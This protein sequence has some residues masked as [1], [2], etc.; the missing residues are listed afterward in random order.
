MAAVGTTGEVSDRRSISRRWRPGDVVDVDA[1]DG[2]EF[3]AVVL[4]PA[5]SGDVEEMSIKFADGVIDDWPIEEFCKPAKISEASSSEQL[6]RYDSEHVVVVGGGVIGLSCC[7]AIARRG[8]KCTLLDAATADTA[9]CSR[10]DT[11]GMHL[12]HDGVYSE[13]VTESTTAWQEME[14]QDPQSRT[15]LTT[16]GSLT[17]G[18]DAEI[19]TIMATHRING[20][21]GANDMYQL[22]V[23]SEQQI[24]NRWHGCNFQAN[25]PQDDAE[26][27]GSMRAVYDG[28][29][30][31]IDM[32]VAM[33]VLADAAQA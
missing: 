15:I 1:E 14:E 9:R 23:L 7:A 28:D 4:G 19:E 13:L 18:T 32:T 25:E 33:Q 8:I 27:T 29:G 30:Y 6:S 20:R 24:H 22:E 3:G 21:V 26:H 16:C 2:M 10:G 31:E 12:A 17:F 11:R 5:I